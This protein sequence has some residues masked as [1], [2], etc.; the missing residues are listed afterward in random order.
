MQQFNGKQ[1]PA[2]RLAKTALAA[3]RLGQCMQTG[4]TRLF[5]RTFQQ[6]RLR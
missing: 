5:L 6:P 4:C 2:G 3:G 1:R